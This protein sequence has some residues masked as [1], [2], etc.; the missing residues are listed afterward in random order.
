MWETGEK[1]RVTDISGFILLVYCDDLQPVLL[2]L[3][4]ESTK[5]CPVFSTKEKLVE[6]SIW[7]G[8][9]Y[10]T[11]PKVILDQREFL[12]SF[13]GTGIMVAADPYIREGKTRWTAFVPAQ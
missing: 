11:R 2:S 10:P 5:L 6:A 13:A 12:S 1:A 3:P 9:T 4:T 8:I 7:M